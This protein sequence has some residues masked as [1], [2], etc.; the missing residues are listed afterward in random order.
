MLDTLFSTR[1][2]TEDVNKLRNRAKL[3]KMPPTAL[4]RTVLRRYLD[5]AQQNEI[6]VN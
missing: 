2:T 6:P 4:A 1:L 3:E 5:D